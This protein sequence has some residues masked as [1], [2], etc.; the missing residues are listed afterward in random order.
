VRA[1]GGCD[2]F[3][4]HVFI[5]CKG[6]ILQSFFYKKRKRKELYFFAFLAPLRDD[7]IY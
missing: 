7:F 3:V 2:Y 6:T 4:F 5:S 1:I